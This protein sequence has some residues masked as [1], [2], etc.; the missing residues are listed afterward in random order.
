[1]SALNFDLN[2]IF[3]H[4]PRNGGTS[5]ESLA[6][7]NGH[8][9]IDYYRDFFQ[10][11]VVGKTMDD[12]FKFAFV[13]NPWD[14]FVSSY[15]YSNKPLE[16]FEEFVT[17]M[18]FGHLPDSIEFKP[19]YQFICDYEKNILV[20]FVGRYENLKE[21]WKK[22]CDRLGVE[23]E[24]PWINKSENRKRDWES[25]YNTKTKKIIFDVY[26]DDFDLFYKNLERE[27]I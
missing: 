14:R 17:D 1:M 11:A 9:K 3:I 10:Y 5:M 20:D 6:G 19:Q 13:R 26:R 7:C 18:S 15:V 23:H 24:L 2:C 21:D 16:E 27:V 22:V 12:F 8:H 4:I 25:Y